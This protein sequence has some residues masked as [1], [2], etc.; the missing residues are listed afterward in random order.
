MPEKSIREMNKYE[1][2]HYSLAARTFH[3]VV[4]GAVIIGLVTLLVGLGLY[5]VAVA[6]Q[7][8]TTAFG[9]TRNALAITEKVVDVRPLA[10]QVMEKYH[11]MSDEERAAVNESEDF[12]R[13][14]LDGDESYEMLMSI[15]DDFKSSSDVFDVYVAMYDEQTSSLVYIADPDTNEETRCPTGYSEA[16]DKRELNKF[17]HW[18]GTGTLY[19]ASNTDRYGWLATSGVPVRDDNGNIVA[20]F[21]ADVTLHNVAKAMNNF[22]LQYVLA[23]TLVMILTGYFLTKHM[24]RTLVAPIN[25]V[26][27]AALSYINDRRAGNHNTDHFKNLG[28]KTGDE[29]ENLALIMADMEAEVSDYENTLTTVTAEKERINTELALATRIQADMLP[30]IYPAFPDR[31]EFDVYATMTPAKEVGGDFYDFFLIDDDHL[32]IVMADVSGKGVPAALFM[33]ASKILIQNHAMT[34]KS[35]KEV[36]ETVNNQICSNNREEMFVTVWFGVLDITTGTVTA[37]NAGHEY[38]ILKSAD[39]GFEVVKDKHGFVIGG[40]EGVKYREYD[41][42]LSPGAKLFLYTDGVTEA[43]NNENEL[44]G[45]DRT[46]QS[47]NLRADGSVQDILKSVKEQIDSFAEGAP[48]FDDITMLCIEYVGKKGM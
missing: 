2:M 23:L 20:F 24:K 7:N 26:A 17:L 43:T 45:M 25:K 39:G 32:G 44:F 42:N 28:I 31:P 1:R 16:V 3:A 35:P 27:E 34:G 47:L 13:F 46:V 30:N 37:A 40:M 8:I 4:I 29:V 10:M 14:S 36:L 48:Q 33:M 22:V 6:D 5:A 21:L 41:I 15:L 12:S 18:D 9:L 11:A 38:P 19:D